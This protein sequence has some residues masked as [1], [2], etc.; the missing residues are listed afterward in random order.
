MLL[1]NFPVF[2]RF[3]AVAAHRVNLA[4]ILETLGELGIK[5]HALSQ[6][7]ERETCSQS[8][9]ECAACGQLT[10]LPLA[11]VRLRAL[12]VVQLRLVQR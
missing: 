3:S 2:Q 1:H 8:C 6:V 5:R 12:V 4:A 9:A 10:I 11:D 7:L